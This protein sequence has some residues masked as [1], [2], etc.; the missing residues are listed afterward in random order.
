MLNSNTGACQVVP[1]APHLITLFELQKLGEFTRYQDRDSKFCSD[2]SDVHSEYPLFETRLKKNRYIDLLIKSKWELVEFVS[3]SKNI[4]NYRQ[5]PLEDSIPYSEYGIAPA[6]V[7]T[8]WQGNQSDIN[9]ASLSKD[10]ELSYEGSITSSEVVNISPPYITFLIESRKEFVSKRTEET[11][12]ITD[13]RISVPKIAPNYPFYNSPIGV[14]HRWINGN[15]PDRDQQQFKELMNICNEMNFHSCQTFFIDYCSLPQ[16]PRT[17]EEES[18][19]R[20]QLPKMNRY[21]RTSTIVLKEGVNDYHTRAWCMF[22]LILSSV[23]D[24]I[25]NKDVLTG[26]LDEAFQLAR[27]FVDWRSYSFEAK[28][29]HGIGFIPGTSISPAKMRS[30]WAHGGGINLVMHNK[31][32]E[33][34]KK[35]LGWFEDHDLKSADMNDI[36]IIVELLDNLLSI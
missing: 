9:S 12:H 30:W 3:F 22:E 21:Y 7:Y 8:S 27:S 36:P 6:A 15:E 11:F 17:D 35:I 16:N 31:E 10:Y 19:F 14:S 20:D 23:R 2:S 34:K 29:K 32:Q 4:I 1:S 18:V 26:E 13:P 33:G 25:L 28:R 5:G 24:S